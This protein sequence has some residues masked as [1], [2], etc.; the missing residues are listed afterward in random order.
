MEL[1]NHNNRNSEIKNS[2]FAI[3]LKFYYAEMCLRKL[4]HSQEKLP[5]IFMLGPTFLTQAFLTELIKS[6]LNHW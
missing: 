6:L 3:W 5:D 2:Q 1:D 4:V